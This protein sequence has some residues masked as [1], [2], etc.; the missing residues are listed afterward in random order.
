MAVAFTLEV[1]ISFGHCDPA[2]IV[3]YPNYYRWFD[4]CFHTYMAKNAGGHVEVCAK[5]GSI[6][7]GIIDSGAT[8]KSPAL[9]NDV[10]QLE[11]SFGETSRKTF[12]LNYTGLINGRIAAEGYEVRGVFLKTKDGLR[13]GEVAP[14]MD[15]LRK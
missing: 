10:L 12:R 14:L 7:L 2:G 5:L 13:G 6:G 15:I 3:Y 11:M 9:Q 1:P 8:F 4:R